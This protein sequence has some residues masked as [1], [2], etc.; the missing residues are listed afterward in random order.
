[1]KKHDLR[2]ICHKRKYKLLRKTG[3]ICR[4]RTENGNRVRLLLFPYGCLYP[5]WDMRYSYSLEA[6]LNKLHKYVEDELWK[7]CT[8]LEK[9]KK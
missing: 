2:T 7:M 3:R 9:L 1:M 8:M 6:A 4:H 5:Y